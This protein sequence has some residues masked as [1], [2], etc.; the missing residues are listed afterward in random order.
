[1][2]CFTITA[3]LT[4]RNLVNCQ[5]KAEIFQED[6]NLMSSSHWLISWVFAAPDTPL[7]GTSQSSAQL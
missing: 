6:I 7:A 4:L 1:M 5:F 2:L 3:I